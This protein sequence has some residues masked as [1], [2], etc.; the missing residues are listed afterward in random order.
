MTAVTEQE[1][2]EITRFGMFDEEVFAEIVT[3]TFADEPCEVHN[4]DRTATHLHIIL[5]CSDEIAK[6]CQGCGE[7]AR[8]VLEH[9]LAH[10]GLICNICRHQHTQGTPFADVVAVV[11][12]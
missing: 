4:C 6:W 12:L 11:P 9:L 8:G 1:Q 10:V 7:R 3:D 5:C 2:A